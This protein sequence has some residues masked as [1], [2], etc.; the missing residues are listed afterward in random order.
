MSDI[1]L[2]RHGSTDLAGTFCGHSD[3]SLNQRGRQQVAAL[4]EEVEGDMIEAV[5]ASDLQRAR[6]T[7]A[8]LA[9]ARAVPLYILPGLREIHFGEWEG[10]NWS[11]VEARDGQYAERWMLEYPNL[12]TPGGEAVDEFE[13]RVLAAVQTLLRSEQR[14]IA[15]VGHAGVMRVVMRRLGGFTDDQCFA[16]TKE[17]CSMVRVSR[18]CAMDAVAVALESFSKGGPR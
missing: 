6:E 9:T 15:I 7:A 14:P 10:L 3:P 17:Y 4:I 11:E 1:L 13:A 16:Q 2:I 5:Y 8:A 12:A 18:T